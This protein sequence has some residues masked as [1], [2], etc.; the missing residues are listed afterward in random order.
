MALKPDD[1]QLVQ[2]LKNG[3]TKVLE[4]LYADYRKDFIRWADKSYSLT[5]V[6]AVDIYQDT[7]IILYENV[8]HDKL[9]VLHSSLKTYLFAIGKNLI[10]KNLRTAE[11]IRPFGE[12]LEDTEFDAREENDEEVIRQQ[13]LAFDLMEKLAEPCKS[14]LQLYYYQKLSMK[15]IADKLAYKNENVAKSQKARCLKF[16]KNSLIIHLRNKA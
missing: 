3:D 7:I 2:S 1:I 5:Y 13:E 10:M 4:E 9:T 12:R 6:E 15:H 11:K 8:I 16:L 14:I